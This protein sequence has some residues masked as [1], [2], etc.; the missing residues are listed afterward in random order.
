MSLR[1]HIVQAENSLTVQ[2]TN[3]R[4]KTWDKKQEKSRTNS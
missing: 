2:R 1:R 3:K 4:K